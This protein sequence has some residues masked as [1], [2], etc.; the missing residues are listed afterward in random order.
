MEFAWQDPAG[1]RGEELRATW[2]SLSILVDGNSVT[3]LQDRRTR[4]VRTEVFLPLFPLAEWIADNWWF[5]Q[6]EAERPD[7]GSTKEFDRRHNLRWAREGFVLP[8]LRFVTLGETIEAAWQ[9]L[10]IPG[11]AVRFLSSG[12]AMLSAREFIETL[13]GFV[14]AVVAR[15]DESGVPATTLHEQWLEIQ[16][17]DAEEREFCRAAARLGADPYAL[18]THLETTILQVARTIRT[19]LLDDFLSLASLDR[20]VDQASALDAASQSIAADSDDIDALRGVRSQ[21][22]PFKKSANP[23]ATGYRFAAELRKNVNGGAWKSRSLDELAGHLGVEHIE[24]CLMPEPVE[25]QFLDALA[26]ANRHNNPKFLIEKTRPDSRQFA[27]CRALFE[28]LTSPQGR[29]AAVSKLR[30]DRQQMNRAFAAEF[31]APHELLKRDLSAALVGEEELEDLAVDYGVSSFVI[32]HQIE[33]HNLA[34]VS[35]E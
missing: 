27:F 23:W 10:E 33:N 29:F 12:R 22:P 21:A 30:T 11:A 6:A 34:R 24:H 2:A 14:D 20:L 7:I 17:T 28:H 25:C 4:S 13:R 16:N 9:P 5:L 15:L 18:D 32:R 8:S 19:E 26:G 3:E 31:L 1:A 35:I